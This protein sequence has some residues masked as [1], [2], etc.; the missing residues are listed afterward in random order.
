MKP[1]LRTLPVKLD[2]HEVA[3]RADELAGEDAAGGGSVTAPYVRVLF[4]DAATGHGWTWRMREDV[5]HQRAEEQVRAWAR[6]GV[7]VTF[8][9]KP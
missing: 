6:D 7:T 5:A 9:V 1:H 4:F 2:P 8:E 3:Q